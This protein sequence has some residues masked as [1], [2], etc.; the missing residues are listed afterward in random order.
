MEASWWLS[1]PFGLGGAALL[2]AGPEMRQQLTDMFNVYVLALCV[3]FGWLL[4]AF[5]Q[6]ATQG[7]A[8]LTTGR[9]VMMCGAV[10]AIVM[11]PI[12]YMLGDYVNGGQV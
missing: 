5:R 6:L 2:F 9:I 12:L 1:V 7:K 8:T 10:L 4:V 11:P 3:A